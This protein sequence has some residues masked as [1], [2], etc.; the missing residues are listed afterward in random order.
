[1]VYRFQYMV[2]ST[3]AKP[4]LS[5]KIN[6]LG[7]AQQKQNKLF[8]QKVLCHCAVFFNTETIDGS[9][10]YR[11][12]DTLCPL[13]FLISLRYHTVNFFYEVESFILEVIEGQGLLVQ[14]RL[15]IPVCK[16]LVFFLANT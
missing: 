1:M 13:I 2:F 12:L 8:M 15:N 10:V 3:G 9:L 14:H 11:D 5:R 4:V 7:Q 6:P 16:Y